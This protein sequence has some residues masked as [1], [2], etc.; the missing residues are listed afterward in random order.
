MSA[1][2]KVQVAE[3]DI[4]LKKIIE[5]INRWVQERLANLHRWIGTIKPGATSFSYKLGSCRESS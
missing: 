1:S 2:T 3:L 4:F 5:Q